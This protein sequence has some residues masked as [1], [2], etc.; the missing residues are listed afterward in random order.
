[1]FLISERSFAGWEYNFAD[2]STNFGNL[3]HGT[4]NSQYTPNSVRNPKPLR[5]CDVYTKLESR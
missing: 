1:M 3:T 5:K 4:S 2:I